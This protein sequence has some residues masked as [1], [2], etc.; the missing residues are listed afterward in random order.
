MSDADEYG[1]LSRRLLLRGGI[2]AGGLVVAGGAEL[3][4]PA[5]ASAVAQPTIFSTDDWNADP[6]RGTIEIL[7]HRP[8]KIIVHHTATANS[9][10]LS[11]AHAFALARSIQ[12]AHFAR[13]FIDTG[14]QFTISRGGFIMAGRHHSKTVL[15]D[16]DRHVLGAHCT[17]QNDVAVGIE[18]EGTYTNVQIRDEHYDKL[19]R[20]C[21]YICQ[22]YG[23]AP[24]NIFGHRDFSATECPGDRLYARLPRLRDDVRAL[25]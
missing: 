10:D 19:V 23:I 2:L 12:Q 21:A 15:L 5:A 25:L 3:L 1:A 9:S 13:G 20:M 14:Q 7:N 11:R 18:N 4:L 17:G 8:T 6:P 16:G 24:R 22:Q